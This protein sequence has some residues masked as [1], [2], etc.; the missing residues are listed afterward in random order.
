MGGLHGVC[1][2]GMPKKDFFPFDSLPVSLK[3]AFGEEKCHIKLRNS[4]TPKKCR[5]ASD[6]TGCSQIT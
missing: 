5:V 4:F 1:K 2:L 6:A 3:I